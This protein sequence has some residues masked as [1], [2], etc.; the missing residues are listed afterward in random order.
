M[1]AARRALILFEDSADLEPRAFGSLIADPG[2]GAFDYL[3]VASG[4]IA[5]CCL[6]MVVRGIVQALKIE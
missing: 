3:I 5:R 4:S 1:K 2:A 6:E